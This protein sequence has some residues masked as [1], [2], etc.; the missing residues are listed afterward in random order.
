MVLSLMFNELSWWLAAWR[1]MG[2]GKLFSGNQIFV[3]ESQLQT[4]RVKLSVKFVL[5]RCHTFCVCI[6]KAYCFYLNLCVLLLTQPMCGW[7]CSEAL[8]WTLSEAA[9]M[10]DYDFVPLKKNHAGPLFCHFFGSVGVWDTTSFQ[11]CSLSS[12]VNHLLKEKL[13]IFIIMILISQY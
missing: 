11:I 7:A 12:V 13:Q 2:D 8:G 3:L 9:F 4:V 10:E 5:F 6:F 1:W